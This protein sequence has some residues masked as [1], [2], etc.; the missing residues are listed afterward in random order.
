VLRRTIMMGKKP[1]MPAKAGKGLAMAA[2]KA[3]GTPAAGKMPAY[4]NGGKVG[5]LPP[6]LM[7]GKR[8]K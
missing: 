7:K 4:K 8:G 6:F 1:A 3:A 2:S 5:K